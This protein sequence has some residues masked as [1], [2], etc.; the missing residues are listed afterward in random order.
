[1]MSDQFR[2]QDC[3]HTGDYASFPFADDVLL[4]MEVGDVFTNAECPKCGALA[5]PVEPETALPETYCKVAWET[6]DLDDLR[7]DWDD[8]RR[9][10]WLK[11]NHA[12]ITGAMISRGWTVIEEM[13]E[14][15][16]RR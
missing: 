2:C 1:M 10:R 9:A 8:D 3:Q 12:E 14:M 16:G 5:Y 6:A 11:E 15:E 4:R 13:L 7:P